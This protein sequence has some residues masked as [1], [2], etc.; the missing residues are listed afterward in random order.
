MHDV[1]SNEILS[2]GNLIITEKVTV[3]AWQKIF[4]KSI[5]AFAP[6]KL[7]SVLNRK[8]ENA[9]GKVIEINTWKA[10]LSQYDHKLDS[11][12]KKGLGERTML[13]GGTDLVQR[14]LYSAF[15]AYCVNEEE[16]IVCRSTANKQW[17]GARLRLDTAVEQLLNAKRKGFIPS[18]AGINQLVDPTRRAFAV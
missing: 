10:K 9:D 4:G 18:S 14:D 17:A 7:M 2:H 16:N 8:A 15:L 13:V 1:Y 3:K 11:Y 12:I 5:N 6:A